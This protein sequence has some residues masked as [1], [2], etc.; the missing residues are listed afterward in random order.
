MEEVDKTDEFKKR[1]EIYVKS[2]YNIREC[3]LRKK[4]IL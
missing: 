2:N 1:I 3:Y 4:E